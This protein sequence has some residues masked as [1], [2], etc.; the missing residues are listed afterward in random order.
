MRRR[1][2]G[3]EQDVHWRSY[4]GIMGAGQIAKIGA[5]SGAVQ[6]CLL[7]PGAQFPAKQAAGKGMV[8]TQRC[9]M[10]LIL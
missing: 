4:H 10:R 6:N 5:I 3:L 1:V 9:S 8:K 2:N 7:D